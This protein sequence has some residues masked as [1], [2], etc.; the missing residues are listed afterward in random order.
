[1]FLN[2]VVTLPVFFSVLALS[3]CI[4]HYFGL[5]TSEGLG[6]KEESLVPITVLGPLSPATLQRA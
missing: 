2:Q 5:W 3:S 6:D 1:M 4:L